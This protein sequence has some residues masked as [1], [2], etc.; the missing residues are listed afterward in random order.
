MYAI[1]IQTMHAIDILLHPT[2]KPT[3]NKSR[4]SVYCGQKRGKALSFGLL[5]NTRKYLA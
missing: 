2:V 4:A 3:W 5:P 1:V